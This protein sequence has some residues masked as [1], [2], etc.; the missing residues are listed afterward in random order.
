[1]P[2]AMAIQSIFRGGPIPRAKGGGSFVFLVCAFLPSVIYYSF[3]HN[4]EVGTLAPRHL[5]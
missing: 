1:M 2:D 3:I 5:P 4:K